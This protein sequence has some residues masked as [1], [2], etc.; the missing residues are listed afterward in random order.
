MEENVRTVGEF[1]KDRVLETR[2]DFGTR[3]EALELEKGYLQ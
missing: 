2:C 3:D 1:S